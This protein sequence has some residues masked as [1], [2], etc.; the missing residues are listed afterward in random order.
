MD[1]INFLEPG[2]LREFV[3]AWV[4]GWRESSQSRGFRNFGAGL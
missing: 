2:K 3:D 1:K 4:R